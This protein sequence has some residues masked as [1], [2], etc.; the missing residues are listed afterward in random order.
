MILSHISFGVLI[1]GILSLTRLYGQVTPEATVESGFPVTATVLVSGEFSRSEG[2]AFNEEGTLFV[3]ANRALWTINIQGDVNK[4]T[5]LYS[6]LGL[7]PYGERDILVADFG[8]TNIFRDGENDDGM[9]WLVT[10]EG[11]KKVVALGIAD[12]NFILVLRDMSFLVSDDGTNKIYRVDQ[13]GQV[14]LYTESINHPNGMVL[15]LDENYLYVA[16]IFQSI[17]PIIPDNRIWRL[18]VENL[19]PVENPTVLANPGTGG[20][21]GLAMDTQ[22]RIYVAA[23]GEGNIWRINPQTGEVVLIA[24]NMP[25]VASLAFGEGVFDPFSI[26]ATSTREGTIWKVSVGISG[27]K[28]TR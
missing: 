17:H 23:N 4:V 8:P 7:A 28:P 19:L 20:H 22:G 18:P 2:I 6:N 25:G 24:E 26:Y 15:S 3:T 16:Q 13:R 14:S 5:D 10:P 9:V 1:L 21:D 11:Q 12:P 27:V